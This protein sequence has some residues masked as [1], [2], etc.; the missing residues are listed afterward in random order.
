MIWRASD[1]HCITSF[2]ILTH[3]RWELF[4]ECSLSRTKGIHDLSHHHRV[5]LINHLK[6]GTLT[7]QAVKSNAAHTHLTISKDPVIIR[8]APSA[9]LLHSHGW[10]AFADGR[11]DRKGLPRL[12]LP[13]SLPTSHHCTQVIV[14][15]T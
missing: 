13:S 5:N 4:N 6:A 1:I 2:S 10:R 9:C 3:C 15:I 11:I 7:I 8:E 12:S 14:E